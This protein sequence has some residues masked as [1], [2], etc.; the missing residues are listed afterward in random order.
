MGHELPR[1]RVP[2]AAEVPPKAAAPA[3]PVGAVKGQPRDAGE[4]T[5]W[6]MNCRALASLSRRKYPRKLPRQP[7][8]WGPSRANHELTHGII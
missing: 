2:I 5:L 4:V 3:V 7:S 1:P 6:A 8:L